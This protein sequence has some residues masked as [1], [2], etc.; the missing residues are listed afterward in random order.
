M[1][2]EDLINAVKRNGFS[3][4]NSNLAVSRIVKYLD[5]DDS[6]KL[7]PTV[8]WIPAR[9]SDHSECAYAGP[10]GLTALFLT[11]GVDEVPSHASE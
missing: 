10:L 7:A 9:R 8:D 2:Q 11:A 5:A 3:Q 6:G 4:N 1:S